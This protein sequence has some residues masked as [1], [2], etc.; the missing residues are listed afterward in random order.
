MDFGVELLVWCFNLLLTMVLKNN[1]KANDVEFLVI[2]ITC[3]SPLGLIALKVWGSQWAGS[4]V[5][6]FCDNAAVVQVVD[7]GK[8]KDLLLATCLRNIWMITA[9]YDI[10][11]S[12]RYIAGSKNVILD[13]LSNIYSDKKVD[14]AKAYPP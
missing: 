4:H 9:I 10:K 2:L 14:Y 8:T 12:I 11:I 1:N 6:L 5:L 3:F 13:L 7:N